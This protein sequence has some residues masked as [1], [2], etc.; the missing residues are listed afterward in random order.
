MADPIFTAMKM[1][2][3]C[4]DDDPA[5]VARMRDVMKV[6]M[7]QLASDDNPDFNSE[8]KTALKKDMEKALNLQLT[9]KNAAWLEV[10]KKHTSNQVANIDLGLS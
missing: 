2:Y 6:L 1:Q 4:G 8:V 3:I 5:E 7:E 10:S 9:D